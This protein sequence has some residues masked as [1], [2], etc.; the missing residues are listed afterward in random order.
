M[1][2][3]ERFVAISRVW[4]SA[5]TIQS[6]MLAQWVAILWRF[7]WIVDTTNSTNPPWSAALD[8]TIRENRQEKTAKNIWTAFAIWF[9]WITHGNCWLVP[10]MELLSWLKSGMCISKIIHRQRGQCSKRYDILNS[11]S[12][13]KWNELL[14]VI[15]IE[16]QL[17]RKRV[18]GCV[19]SLQLHSSQTIYIGT[20]ACEIY[21]LEYQTF[22]L[23]LQITCNTCIV[24]DIAFP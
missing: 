14:L 20:D 2:A 24:N 18:S 8:A 4:K 16:F 13:P 12:W 7:V 15:E 10:A 9:T 6:C 11:N 21:T 22:T 19:T 5:R 23:K 3:S 1:R 17:K